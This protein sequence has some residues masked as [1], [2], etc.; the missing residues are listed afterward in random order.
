MDRGAISARMKQHYEAT[1]QAGDAWSLEI[2]SYEQA[3]YRAQLQ[4]LADQHYNRVLELGCGSGCFTAMLASVAEHV[5][6]LDIADGAVERARRQCADLPTRQVEFIVAD[7]MNYDVKGS[8]PW[9]V[10]VLSEVIYCLGWLYPMFDVAWFAAALFDATRDGGRLLISNTLG[11]DRDHLLR[12]W[13][14]RT[15]RDMLINVG[16]TLTREEVFEDYKEGQK[17][18]VLM[19]LLTRHKP[20]CEPT[21][22]S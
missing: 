9:D 10:I 21:T 13:L 5:S 2:S 12:P 22:F 4:M 17:F 1:W 7:A 14:I 20:S 8:G 19:S 11:H 3:R 18:E 6:A 16:F 15:Y